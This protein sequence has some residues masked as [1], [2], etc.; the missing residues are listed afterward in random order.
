MDYLIQEGREDINRIATSQL[1]NLNYIIRKTTYIKE[2]K[3]LLIQYD[4]IIS[5]GSHDIG[6]CTIVEHVIHLITKKPI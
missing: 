2:V 5:K 6:N 3:E 4:E 1:I